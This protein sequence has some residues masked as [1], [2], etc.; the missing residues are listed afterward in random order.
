M[1]ILGGGDVGQSI[2]HRDP[3]ELAERETQEGCH[4]DKAESSRR[5]STWVS[6]LTPWL[7]SWGEGTWHRFPEESLCPLPGLPGVCRRKCMPTRSWPP[8][9][10]LKPSCAPP[11]AGCCP[12]AGLTEVLWALLAWT[13][14]PRTSPLPASFPVMPKGKGTLKPA[15]MGMVSFH[16]Q[17]PRR[18]RGVSRLDI[19]G[20]PAVETTCPDSSKQTNKMLN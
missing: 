9:A 15:V 5:P 8:W 7:C 6:P 20:T 19:S 13:S 11:P 3:K 14:H 10:L 4:C 16:Q 18:S 17:A 1:S 2:P 12:P